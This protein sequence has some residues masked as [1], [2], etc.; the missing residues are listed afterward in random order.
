[1]FD[2][3]T[4]SKL[5][6]TSVTLDK[7]KPI[8]VWHKIFYIHTRSMGPVF[9]DVEFRRELSLIELK[10]LMLRQQGNFVRQATH[11]NALS[12]IKSDLI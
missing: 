4:T 8:L 9:N 11:Y 3:E 12:E 6:V 10:C 2:A 5:C 7:I 1:M